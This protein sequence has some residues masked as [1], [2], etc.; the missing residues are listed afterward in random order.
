MRSFIRSLVVTASAPFALVATVATALSTTLAAPLVAQSS[1]PT[2]SVF[3][4]APYAGYMV[5][6]NYLNGPVGTTLTS[7]PGALYGVQ[8]ALSLSQNLQLVGNIGTTSSS[9]Q[10]GIPFLGGLS[11]GNSR[12]LM[13]DADLEYD[14]GGAS[15]SSAKFTPFIQAGIGQMKYDINASVLET[16]ATN[17][18]ENVGIGADFALGRGMAL[19]VLAKDYIGKFDFHDATGLGINGS[20]AHN[21]GFTAGLRFDF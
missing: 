4:I 6:G 3:H 13:Y 11:V 21:L 7:K 15:V 2:A 18:A 10:V 5:F 17:L 20:T 8:A 12:M 1:T 9:M 16:H 14:F 19:R